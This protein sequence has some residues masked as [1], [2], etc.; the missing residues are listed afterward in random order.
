M[1]ALFRELALR[2]CRA[3]VPGPA[4]G[5]REHHG[6]ALW[7]RSQINSARA[8][9]AMSECWNWC[10]SANRSNTRAPILLLPCAS[11]VPD[12]GGPSHFSRI[13][14]RVAAARASALH[15]R[16]AT[17]ASREVPTEFLLCGRH[18]APLFYASTQPRVA[19][20]QLVG[21][22]EGALT[23]GRRCSKWTYIGKTL[24]SHPCACKMESLA[25]YGFS[26]VSSART[27]HV[28]HALQM[29]S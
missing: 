1:A 26:L 9:E 2:N 11:R 22:R 14:C 28:S 5:T 18:R 19:C 16:G 8:R 13:R 23:N 6:G 27:V 12:F 29:S 21:F 17:R 3:C 24:R 7:L 25:S 4:G 15:V 10:A 20:A